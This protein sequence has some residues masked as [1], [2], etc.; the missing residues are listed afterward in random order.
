MEDEDD[1]TD[2]VI[3]QK[4]ER[5]ESKRIQRLK[6]CKEREDI[7]GTTAALVSKLLVN[8]PQCNQQL[9]ATRFALHYERCLNK[10]RARTN[11]NHS[12]ART[13]EE[14]WTAECFVC[15]SLEAPE[16]MLLCDGCSRVFHLWCLIP[17][18]EEVPSGVWMCGHCTQKLVDPKKLFASR[19]TRSKEKLTAADKVKKGRIAAGFDIVEFV[20]DLCDETIP[21]DETRFRCLTCGEFD[22][23]IKC[24]GK[25][26]LGHRSTHAMA[27][28]KL[29]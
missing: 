29:S 19:N 21:D 14:T 10:C 22:V 27:E 20:C 9:G 25:G 5:L 7:F 6:T 8:C 15:H 11:S 2:F 16:S 1:Q 18:L 13:K 3:M 28:I 26:G 17:R 24:K 4:K 23:C 12:K